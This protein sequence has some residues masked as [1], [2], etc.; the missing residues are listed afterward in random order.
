V[1][2]RLLQA[3]HRCRV[4]P[5]TDEGRIAAL[6]AQVLDP[7]L[8]AAA[9]EADLQAL[10]SRCPASRMPWQYLAELGFEGNRDDYGAL[11]N[12]NLARVLN[13]RRGIPITLGVVLIRVARVA[14]RQ[15]VGI[16]FPGHFIVEVDE[17]LVD[18][19]VLQPL[20]RSEFLE[21]LPAAARELSERALFAP[22]SPVAV[23]VR[24][25]NN[26]KLGY[27][28]QGA[29]HRLLDVLDAQLELAPE[30]PAL[31]LER[32]D[33]WGRLGLAAPAREAFERALALVSDAASEDAEQLRR[34]VRAR[35]DELGGSDDVVH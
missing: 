8:E 12:S 34:A 3:F 30:Q 26:I 16:N 31:H 22:A 5:E 13:S 24:M 25:L 11:D 19:F 18:P 1:E 9:V 29:W 32:G 28:R 20:N 17:D 4:E 23:G 15:A 14:G 6:I 21:R 35:L 7:G 10:A 2:Q 33:V 27:S